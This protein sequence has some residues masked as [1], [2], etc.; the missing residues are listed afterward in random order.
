MS[1]P[2]ARLVQMGNT[3]MFLDEETTEEV[4][5]DDTMPTTTSDD[6]ATDMPADKEEAA[7]EGTEM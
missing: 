7:T 5:G 4:A 3:N 6:T 1:L 2:C